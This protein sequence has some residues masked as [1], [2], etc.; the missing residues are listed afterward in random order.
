MPHLF[1]GSRRSRSHAPLCSSRCSLPPDI[2]LPRR[3]TTSPPMAQPTP[4]Q[5]KSRVYT[6]IQADALQ[7]S[8]V[9]KH[10]WRSEV[11]GKIVE[12]DIDIQLFLSYFMPSVAEMPPS[13]AADPFH[14]PV[15]GKETDMYKPLCDGLKNL[16]KDFPKQ[17]RLSFHN[18][19]HEEIKFPFLLCQRDQHA[20][21]PDVVAS[22]PGR[23]FAPRNKD[24]DHDRWRDISVVFEIKNV[25]SEDPMLYCSERND[26]T[27]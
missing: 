4:R 12:M 19:A 15:G 1:K 21:K 23:T 25:E 11:E 14:V 18:N 24:D 22:L 16:V 17:K 8:E 9:N 10:G 13:Q 26:E 20:T 27:L 5:M 3:R 6:I 2:H 7:S